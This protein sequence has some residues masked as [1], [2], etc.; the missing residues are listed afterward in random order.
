MHAFVCLLTHV[1]HLTI[2]PFVH[3]YML[4][5]LMPSASQHRGYDPNDHVF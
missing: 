1:L 3:R 5:T 4:L 2:H